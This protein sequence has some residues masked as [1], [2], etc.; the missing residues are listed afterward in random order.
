MAYFC[1][2]TETSS[3]ETNW[4][5]LNYFFSDVLVN[6]L[7]AHFVAAWT[8]Q[9]LDIVAQIFNPWHVFVKLTLNTHIDIIGF[10]IDAIYFSMLLK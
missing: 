10:Q 1:K 5:K 8:I 9:I 2:C 4:N 7:S 6:S 3:P